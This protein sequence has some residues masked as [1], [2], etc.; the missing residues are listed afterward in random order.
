MPE[1]PAADEGAGGSMLRADV[2]GRYNND[3]LVWQSDLQLP[4]LAGAALTHRPAGSA[5]T[6]CPVISIMDFKQI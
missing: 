2:R 1:K 5:A 4:Q 6:M 3:V